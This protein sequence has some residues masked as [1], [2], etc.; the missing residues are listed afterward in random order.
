MSRTI[1]SFYLFIFLWLPLFS[2]DILVRTPE[3]FN[4]LVDAEPTETIESIQSRIDACLN[5]D[6]IEI[7]TAEYCIEDCFTNQANEVTE[8]WMDF[9][10][11]L[12]KKNP[13]VTVQR[14]YEIPLAQNHRD[15]ITFVVKTLANK[16]IPTILKTKS[17]LDAAGVRLKPVHPFRFL[18]CIFCDEELKVGIRNIKK[19]GW[20]WGD[21]FS[22]LVGSLNEEYARNNLNEEY[23]TD[24]AANLK[25]N[26]NLIVNV[27]QA[28]Q[29]EKL[30]EILIVNVPRSGN[31]G[32]YDM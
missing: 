13:T 15:D 20:I 31:A 26:P 17:A 4:F 1:Y 11:N 14:I 10:F 21:F 2:I 19:R 24:F 16:S 9:T 18:E 6:F 3:G 22:G 30:V 27:I 12:F 7:E 29:W 32:R 25:I 28:K 5:K 8:F 23:I